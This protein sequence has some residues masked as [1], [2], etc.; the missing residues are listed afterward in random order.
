MAF[1]FNNISAETGLYGGL[2]LAGLAGGFTHCIL[3]CGPFA[4]A[5]S[6]HTQTRSNFL[7][8]IRSSLLLPYHLG[9]MTTYVVLAII[10]STVLNA[11]LFFSPLK[12]FLGAAL[13]L[14][15]ALIFMINAI[16]AL[17]SI[18]PYLVRITLPVPRTI[19]MKMCK[20]FIACRGTW[21]RYALGLLLGFMP[22]GLVMAAFMT[23]AALD[24]PF[25]ALIGMSLFSLGT[26]P[27][28]I[29]A[30]AGGQI[31]YVRYPRAVPALRMA[32]LT[33]STSVLLITAGKMIFL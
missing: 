16:P 8:K 10:F 30:A 11:A 9:R 3:M 13:L 17:G 32:A 28:L 18:F 24:S 25:K 5:Q 6:S 19:I 1:C 27:A 22:C 20:P 26:M 2:F 31:A 14:T 23:V 12:N 33:I 4:I 7:E 15:A 29:V 21:R